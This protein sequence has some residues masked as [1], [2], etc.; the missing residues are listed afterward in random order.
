MFNFLFKQDTKSKAKRDQYRP[1]TIGKNL[2]SPINDYG[3]CFSCDG[4]G[5]RT[6]ECKVCNGIG[7]H[8][9]QCRACQGSGEYYLPAMK[10]F[11]CLGTGTKYGKKCPRCQATGD[12]KPCITKECRNCSGTGRY[13][14]T[15]RKC[16]GSCHF[17]VECRKCGGSGWYR[18]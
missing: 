3:T 16:S 8:V 11:E 5:R 17:T 15:C 6:L 13:S 10:C 7:Y 18:F 14:A 4:T 12:F 2:I 9:G 1:S